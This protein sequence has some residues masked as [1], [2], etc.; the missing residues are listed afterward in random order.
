MEFLN[1]NIQCADVTKEELV[2]LF[3]E[4]TTIT[5]S[6]LKLMKLS[7]IDF[8]CPILGKLISGEW[9]KY[10]HINIYR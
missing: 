6:G 5:A 9:S 3:A 7:V 2:G 4:D 10:M 1:C 8:P